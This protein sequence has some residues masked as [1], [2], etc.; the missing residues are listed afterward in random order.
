MLKCDRC[1]NEIKWGFKISMFN[2]DTLCPD[3]I[4]EE[5]K[6]PDYEYACEKERE[7]TK[8]GNYNFHGVGWPGAH[9][10]VKR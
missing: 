9:G 10:R 5:Q 1:G 6:H 4:E 2:T 7:E 3:C 8:K